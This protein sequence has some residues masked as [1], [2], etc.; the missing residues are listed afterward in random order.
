MEDLDIARNI[1]SDRLEKL[2][3]AGVFEPRLYSERPPRFEYRLTDKGK[4]LMD[5][6]LA[7]WRFGDRWTPPES[8]EL[9]DLIHVDCGEATGMVPTCKHCGGEL[10]RSNLRIEPNLEVVD[11]R[12]AAASD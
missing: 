12:L 5:V 3:S 7:L 4:D 10:M 1:L 9:R 2:T 8:G 6:L 11:R